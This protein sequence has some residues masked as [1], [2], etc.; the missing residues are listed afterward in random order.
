[1]RWVGVSVERLAGDGA[2]PPHRAEAGG[3]GVPATDAADLRVRD[4]RARLAQAGDRDRRAEP[5][6]DAEECYC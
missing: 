2:L 6:V 3:V 1:M 5:R 4:V